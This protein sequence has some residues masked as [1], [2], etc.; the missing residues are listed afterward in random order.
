MIVQRNEWFTWTTLIDSP[1]E[2]IIRNDPEVTWKNDH[3]YASI[4]QT[5][6]R[7]VSI[8]KQESVFI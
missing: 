7:N 8:S 6:V 1:T 5:L 2:L 4:I 3:I